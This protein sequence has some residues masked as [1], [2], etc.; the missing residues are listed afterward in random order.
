[1]ETT[2]KLIPSFIAINKVGDD[3]DPFHDYF[4]E[5]LKEKDQYWYFGEILK[6]VI[7]LLE[8]EDG[9]TFIEKLVELR[10]FWNY[11][12][13]NDQ[14]IIDF[15][16]SLD[17][18]GRK[19]SVKYLRDDGRMWFPG[20]S[21]GEKVENLL[22]DLDTDGFSKIVKDIT[23][24]ELRTFEDLQYIETLQ[25]LKGTGWS[26]GSLSML[27]DQRLSMYWRRYPT[28]RKTKIK[29]YKFGVPKY[30]DPILYNGVW[31]YGKNV[32]MEEVEVDEYYLGEGWESYYGIIGRVVKYDGEEVY[33]G[34]GELVYGEVKFYPDPC[35]VWIVADISNLTIGPE[36]RELELIVENS[37]NLLSPCTKVT[38]FPVSFQESG[39]NQVRDEV[40]LE[41]V[42]YYSVVLK[43]DGSRIL[44]NPD[45]LAEG[46]LVVQN[47]VEEYDRKTE[48]YT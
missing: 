22:S 5:R 13:T 30:G 48:V 21:E 35:E 1:M 6:D 32:Y 24:R 36:L 12:T 44:K 34:S 41:E 7:Y 10:L 45:E 16:N 38:F 33:T 26:I 23:G 42:R 8:D 20:V 2:R 9:R 19:Y 40:V 46:D 14:E 28:G 31:V 43:E 29:R 37:K 17:I 47:K 11:L 15:V 27:T 25:R 39:P 18:A 3:F 4:P